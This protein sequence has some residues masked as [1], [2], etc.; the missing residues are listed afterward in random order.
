M[1]TIAVIFPFVA[2]TDPVVAVRTK[3]PLGQSLGQTFPVSIRFDRVHRNQS[4]TALFI[5]RGQRLAGSDTGDAGSICAHLLLTAPTIIGT[6][7]AVFTVIWVAMPVPAPRVFTRPLET[8]SL[9]VVAVGSVFHVIVITPCF[10]VT[11]VL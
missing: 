7:R 5:I 9:V 3:R 2:V 1:R 4:R 11:F 10:W 8:P 6:G